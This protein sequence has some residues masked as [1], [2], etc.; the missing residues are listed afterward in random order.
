MTQFNRNRFLR[1]LKNDFL[2][3]KKKIL[4]ILGVITGLVFAIYTLVG[5]GVVGADSIAGLNTDI[6]K[7]PESLKK[8]LAFFTHENVMAVLT[9]ASYASY[10]WGIA[11]FVIMTRVFANLQ[12]RKQEIDFLTLP[13][14]NL[15]KWSSR[16]AYVSLISIAGLVAHS[17]GYA[18]SLL[19]IYPFNS[20]F[21]N[22]SLALYGSSGV[23][24]ELGVTGLCKNM[25]LPMVYISYVGLGMILIWAGTRFRRNA[26]LYTALWGLGIYCALVV[27]GALGMGIYIAT[28]G[29]FDH[30]SDSGIIFT[31]IVNSVMRIIVVLMGLSFVVGLV[32]LPRSYKRFCRRQLEMNK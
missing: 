29:V 25:Y 14:T 32:L 3:N 5:F 22:E 31:E 23:L 8:F 24:E 2:L 6:T 12:D 1:L 27:F 21:V 28:S 19:V 10:V 20:G 9:A 7:A 30:V 13:A 4:I 11:S 17:L 18:I 26:W 15:E 16:V